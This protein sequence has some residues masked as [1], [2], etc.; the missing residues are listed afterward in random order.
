MKRMTVLSCWVV[1]AGLASAWVGCNSD[2]ALS[3]VGPDGASDATPAG[4]A[5]LESGR[6]YAK[7]PL[8]AHIDASASAEGCDNSQGPYITLTGELQLGG[9]NGRLIFRNNER[10]THERIE[11]STV[12]VV[13]LNEGEVIRFAKQPPRGGVGGNPYIWIQFCD[14][15]WNAISKPTLLGRCVQGLSTTSLDFGLLSECNVQVTSGDCDNSGG[16]NITLSGEL[17]LGGINAKLIFTNNARWTHMREE[18]TQ[19]S[20]V[21]LPAGKSITFAKQ[22]P[23]GGVGGNPRIYFQ[24]TDAS[25]KS[26]SDEFYIGRCV[27]LG[28]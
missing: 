15:S 23:Q 4:K 14:A 16:P 19:V 18:P 22:P 1:L 28:Q 13:V 11:E 3:P 9:L 20:I 7:L 24:F 5:L 26:L 2:R 12:D 10:G 25:G 6:V 8:A 17:R 21:I 27:Q